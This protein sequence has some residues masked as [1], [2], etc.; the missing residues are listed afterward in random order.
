[1]RRRHLAVGGVVAAL[2]VAGAQLVAVVALLGGP[3][4]ATGPGDD[5]DGVATG[6]AMGDDDAVRSVVAYGG[7]GAWVDGYDYDPALGQPG[8][9]P[10][11]GPD[12]VGAMAEHGVRTLYLQGAMDRG[13]PDVGVTAPDE[14]GELLRRAHDEGIRVVAWYLPRL[15]DLDRDVAFVEA[16]DGFTHDGHRFD[17]LAIDIEW[18]EAVPDHE[19]RSAR[20]V[21]LSERVRAV[22]GEDA[23]GAIVPSPVHLEVVNTTFWPGFPWEELAPLYDAWMTMGYWTERPPESG[24]RHGYGYTAE[25][26]ARLRRLLGDEDAVVHPIGG[27]GSAVTP[28]DLDGYLEALSAT[29]AVGGSVYDWATLAEPARAQLAEALGDALEADPGP[30]ATTDD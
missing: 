14:V 5:V 21:E 29:D 10:A 26:V 19:E 20:V 17:G 18:R 24:L 28:E 30:P 4:E 12:D 11:I 8:R 3:D 27:I 2:L 15:G 22:V 25:N 9:P 23:L 7:Q 6:L 16:L 13:Q 1:M